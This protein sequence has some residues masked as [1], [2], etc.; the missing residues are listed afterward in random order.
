MGWGEMWPYLG[1]VMVVW[2]PRKKRTDGIHYGARQ[3]WSLLDLGWNTGHAPEPGLR[4]TGE[5]ATV[6][7]RVWTKKPL[8]VVDGGRH[9]RSL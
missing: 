2:G 4:W 6:R 1:M 8:R 5:D 3:S 7:S 9:R